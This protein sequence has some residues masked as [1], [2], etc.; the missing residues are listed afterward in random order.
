MSAL[1]GA[2][3]DPSGVCA[4]KRVVHGLGQLHANEAVDAHHRSGW[5]TSIRRCGRWRRGPSARSRIAAPRRASARARRSRRERAAPGWLGARPAQRRREHRR[6][7]LG[8]P[9]GR[10]Q[11]SVR[12]ISAGRLARSTTF[13]P[14]PGSP[15]GAD[16]TA[17]A[18]CATWLRGRAAR[19]GSATA[20]DALIGAL[21]IRSGRC[22][23]R[24]RG[25]SARSPTEARSERAGRQP[26][27]RTSWK[28]ARWRLGA[29]RGQRTLGRNIVI[30]RLRHTRI[31]VMAGTLGAGRRGHAARLR[32]QP[33]HRRPHR[34][35]DRCRCR[36]RL[37]HRHRMSAGTALAV[38]EGERI[39]AAS[40]SQRAGRGVEGRGRRRAGAGSSLCS[41]GSTRRFPRR[42]S[43]RPCATQDADVRQQAV[44]CWPIR[45]MRSNR[46]PC[47]RR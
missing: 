19:I 39:P 10:G 17:M 27:R 6:A 24:R 2:L 29:G 20:V 43:P 45:R 18:A 12:E 26:E 3:G 37:R 22:A 14:C 38:G 34:C 40:D 47:W 7:R 11:H 35:R 46:T 8:N 36:H 16:R 31:V 25:P 41:R 30:Q 28:S 44:R 13:A 23:R 9:P 1:T 21:R 42:R 4:A 32:A 5:T 33:R 15:G